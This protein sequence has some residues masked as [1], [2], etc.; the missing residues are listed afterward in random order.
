MSKLADALAAPPLTVGVC[1][2]C[3]LIVDH[4]DRKA[5]DSALANP[6]WS[7]AAL[8]RV[9]ADNDIPVGESAVS[10]HRRR[11]VKKTTR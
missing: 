3:A 9:L 2:V 4:P 7:H 10:N 6:R 11:C 8:S 5:I 1:K